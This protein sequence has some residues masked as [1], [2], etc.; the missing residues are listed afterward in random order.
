MPTTRGGAS[1]G[2]GESTGED[3]AADR[4]R[5]GALPDYVVEDLLASERRR[6]MLSI[7]ADRSTRVVLDDLVRATLAAERNTD[8]TEISR[9][10][11]REA[12]IDVFENELPKLTAVDVVHYDSLVGT[13]ELTNRT[14]AR[15]VADGR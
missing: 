3:E 13:V 14:V 1:A 2:G 5:G 11:C 15:R 7:L 4:K 8:A 10:E 9:E 12:R 6:R